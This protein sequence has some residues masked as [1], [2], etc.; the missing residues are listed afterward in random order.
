MLASPFF[1]AAMTTI[2]AG[3]VR[4]PPVFERHFF[5][6][7]FYAL[8]AAALHLTTLTS[9]DRRLGRIDDGATWL[10]LPS[11][12]FRILTAVY[13]ASAACFAFFLF[14]SIGRSNL[15]AV[16]NRA[17]FLAGIAAAGCQGRVAAG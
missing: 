7:I 11:R 9:F 13:F 3:P 10:C 16:W 14:L 1:W 5:W 4:M 8:C 15:R 6:I 12:P 17:D 2:E